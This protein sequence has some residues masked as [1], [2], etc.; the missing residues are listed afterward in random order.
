MVPSDFTKNQGLILEKDAENITHYL[1]SLIQAGHQPKEFMIL[2]RYNDG[3][4]VYARAQKLSVFLL[5]LAEIGRLVS[6][7]NL[8]SWFCF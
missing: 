5:A 4:D 7:R 6:R 2:T 1:Q 8:M 3:M